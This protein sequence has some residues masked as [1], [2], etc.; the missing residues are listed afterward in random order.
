MNSWLTSN[1]LYIEQITSGRSNVFL[2]T[3]KDKVVLVD[4]SVAR[5][6]SKIERRLQNLNIEH[7]D[8]LALTHSHY[9]HSANADCIRKKYGAKIIVHRSE[10]DY[11]S[12]GE[13]ILPLGTNKITRFVTNQ[14]G[15]KYL[16]MFNT[17]PC[18]ADVLIDDEYI[19]PGFDNLLRIIHTPGHT[20]GC[21]SLIADNEIALVGDAMFGVFPGS[22]FP[23][24][25]N[26]V[27]NMVKS[28][29][30]LLDTG[31]KTFLPSHGSANKRA[32]VIKGWKKRSQ[33]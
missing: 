12:R 8:Y 22:I 16:S 2:I 24:Y 21:I 17:Y 7:I 19:I 27:D 5:N 3:W 32:L 14:F 25:G 11:F 10:A 4:T 6:L 1:G 26:D 15:K 13:N 23:P 18:E 30:K 29:K 9:D 33:K 31:C 20:S 28:W